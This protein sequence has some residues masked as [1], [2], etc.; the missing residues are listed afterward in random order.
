[1]RVYA[2]PRRFIALGTV[3]AEGRLEPQRV[4]RR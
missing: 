4:F 2:E 1:V 3:T